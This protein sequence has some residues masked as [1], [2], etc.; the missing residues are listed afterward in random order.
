[1]SN[2]SQRLLQARAFFALLREARGA[3]EKIAFCAYALRGRRVESSGS[4]ELVLNFK[5]AKLCLGRGAGE[6]YAYVEI[7]VDDDYE[8]S[9][10][11]IDDSG[12][13]IVD[14]GA[15]I[16]VFSLAAAQRFPRSPIYSLEPG[17]APFGRLVRNVNLNGATAIHPLNAAAWSAC[18]FVNFSENS[19]TTVASVANDGETPVEAITLDALCQRY[20][21]ARLGLLK[22]DVEGA[23]M[24]VLRGGSE[25]LI[26]TERVVVE[27]HSA[28]LASEVEAL[29]GARFTKVS[30]RRVPQGG[31]VIRFVQSGISR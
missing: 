17:A 15:N 3:R 22:I 21:I 26:V 24:E 29:L 13:A 28:S 12:E 10:L 6:L 4:G 19:A 25:A 9:R 23:E 16:G 7:F 31:G 11:T 14:V 5:R 20:A 30:E 27:C 2:L 8:L 18:G 1:M